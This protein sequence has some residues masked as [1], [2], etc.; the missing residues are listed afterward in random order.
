[1]PDYKDLLRRANESIAKVNSQRAI[2]NTEDRKMMIAMLGQDIVEAIK[3]AIKALQVTKE[4]LKQALSNVKITAPIEQPEVVV[5]VPP[6]EIP[7]IRVDVPEVRVPAPIVNVAP[8]PVR[9]PDINFPDEMNVRGWIGVMGYD[10]GLLSN[11]LPVQLR[12]A[13]GKPINLGEGL[14]PVL[15]ITGGGGNGGGGLAHTVKIGGIPESSWGSVINADGRLKV[16]TNDGSSASLVSQVSGAIW[17]VNIAQADVS[18]PVFQV[19]GNI[20]SVKVTSFDTSVGAALVDS[21]GVQYSG[22]NPVPVTG[23]VTVTGSLTSVVATGPTAVDANDDGTAPIQTGGIARTAN[24]TA[25][26]NGDVV[27]STH[28][29]L[30]RILNRPVQVRDLIVTAYASVT[31]GTEATLL[32]AS[33]GSYHDLVYIMA[34]NNSDAAATIDVRPV[35]SGNVVMTI[36]VPANGTAGVA[37][38][39][40]IPQS[41]TG[42]NWTIDMGDITGTTVYVTALFSREV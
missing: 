2:S 21:S 19:S 10:R 33:A 12:D 36:Q 37:C 17:S 6:I 15:N 20:D 41:D 23:T 28:D 25:V 40:P 26:A 3:P 16:E 38:P 7:D 27:K 13:T 30:G 11:P 42:N 18:V 32:A 24:P 39:V 1:M 8:T 34:A 5:N 31:N 22:S 29:D 14:N 35:T 9:L 4:D